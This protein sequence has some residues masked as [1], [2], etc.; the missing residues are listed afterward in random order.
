MKFLTVSLLAATL[1]AP[2]SA[3]Q[4]FFYDSTTTLQDSGGTPWSV[5]LDVQLGAFTDGFVPTA[6]NLLD[7][8]SYWTTGLLGAGYYDPVGPEWD[9]SLTLLDNTLLPVGAPLYLMV[10]GNLIGPASEVAL[11]SDAAWQVGVNDPLD[12]FPVLLEFSDESF[13]VVGSLDWSAGLAG[14][15]AINFTPVPEPATWGA[16]GAIAL[17][18]AAAWR[19]RRSNALAVHA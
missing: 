15:A 1:A 5:S 18:A 2:L 11:F 13:A 12:L 4:Y 19:R 9:A 8:S 17:L 7:W 14:T 6:D 16:A 10:W 3:T